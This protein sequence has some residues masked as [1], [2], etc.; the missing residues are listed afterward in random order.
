[1]KNN[2]NNNKIKNNNNDD[3]NIMIN[4]NEENNNILED[5]I[6]GD[7]KNNKNNKIQNKLNKDNKIESNNT[8][9]DEDFENFKYD[10]EKEEKNNIT[11]NLFDSN[12]KKRTFSAEAFSEIKKNANLISN[13]LKL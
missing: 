8:I 7:D 3:L 11:K 2:D 10:P 12:I 5:L 9:I 1:M 4:L 13:K 6:F